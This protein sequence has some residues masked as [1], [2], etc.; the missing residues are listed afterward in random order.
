MCFTVTR[1]LL[2]QPVE[3]MWP[4]FKLYWKEPE[5]LFRLN[6]AADFSRSWVQFETFCCWYDIKMIPKTIPHWLTLFY[7]V[8]WSSHNRNQKQHY[9][10]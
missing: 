4:L 3:G 8:K 2:C 1:G 9:L 5:R 7:I 6:S 10:S